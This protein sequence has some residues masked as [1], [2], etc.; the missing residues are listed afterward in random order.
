MKAGRALEVNYKNTFDCFRRTLSHEGL[1]GLYRGHLATMLREIP[2]NGAWFAT[3]EIACNAIARQLNCKRNELG[4]MSLIV[5]G[6]VGGMAYWGA[7]YP[8]DTVK[9]VMQTAS[10]KSKEGFGQVFLRVSCYYFLFSAGDL[11]LS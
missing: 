6:G 11:T 7:F 4:P 9:S 1:R 2:G 10:V 3:Y 5:A 8:A